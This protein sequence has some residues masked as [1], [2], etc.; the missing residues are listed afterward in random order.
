MIPPASYCNY[1]QTDSK[2][3]TGCPI[4]KLK[5]STE[6]EKCR[7]FF[8]DEYI[9]IGWL[10]SNVTHLALPLGP[11]QTFI[12]RRKSLPSEIFSV[13]TFFVS[14]GISG[15]T[16]PVQSSVSWILSL[17]DYYKCTDEI[18]SD[19]WQF[20]IRINFKNDWQNHVFGLNEQEITPGK[21]ELAGKGTLS[22]S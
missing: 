20:L 3:R 4:T 6:P 9:L 16:V 19:I 8:R 2:N 17:Y 11:T 10:L 21:N 5:I 14:N 22:P 7:D 1:Y 15:G 12:F 18:L 13:S